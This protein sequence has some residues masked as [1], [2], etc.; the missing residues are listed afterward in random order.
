M[1]R[2]TEAASHDVWEELKKRLSK[3]LVDA[4]FKKRG[5]GFWK[6][7]EDGS[8][9]SGISFGAKVGRQPGSPLDIGFRI[10]GGTKELH[11]RCNGRHGVKF[12]PSPAAAQFDAYFTDGN[13]GKVWLIT[14]TSSVEQ[15][16][17]EISK[18]LETEGVPI[19]NLMLD[20]ATLIKALKAHK[21]NPSDALSLEETLRVLEQEI[22]P[23]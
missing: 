23:G 6:T 12:E 4:G 11:E 14:P 19:A 2:A 10:L 3:F 17:A 9:F 7:A 8:V 1:S 15:L 21:V 13:C 22:K 20:R 16:Y 18:R 5:G